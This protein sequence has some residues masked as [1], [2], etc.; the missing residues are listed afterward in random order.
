MI[1]VELGYQYFAVSEKD[2]A[3]P[4]L[5]ALSRAFPVEL[6]IID[7]EAKYK[8][9]PSRYR[10]EVRFGVPQIEPVEVPVISKESTDDSP[11]F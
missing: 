1:I 4:F 3:L 10:I 7:D 8:R 5:E 2:A 11:A 9:M 6:K